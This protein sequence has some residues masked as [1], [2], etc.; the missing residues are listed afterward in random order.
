[1]GRGLRVLAL[2]EG[3]RCSVRG[4]MGIDGRKIIVAPIP[5]NRR[6]LRRRVHVGGDLGT[7]TGER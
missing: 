5:V 2:D 7:R 3:H 4:G 1:M 6:V